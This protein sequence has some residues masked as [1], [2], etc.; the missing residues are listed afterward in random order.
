MLKEEKRRV[1]ATTPHPLLRTLLIAE[2]LG[3]VLSPRDFIGI[4]VEVESLGFFATHALIT[5]VK[6]G[7]AS[8]TAKKPTP[9]LIA[10]L[11]LLYR[12]PP[13][14][15]VLKV[16]RVDDILAVY[17]S[18]NEETIIAIYEPGL[19]IEV[20]NLK[21][22]KQ[23]D[24]VVAAKYIVIPPWLNKKID[25]EPKMTIR[26]WRVYRANG[27]YREIVLANLSLL[28]SAA[29]NRLATLLV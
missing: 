17:V 3:K 15:A 2:E 29:Q 8:T 10:Y 19:G 25:A 12:H 6:L 1:A 13:L 26:G 24:V 9:K 21:R 14:F 27:E 18:D 20:K 7:V 11:I 5:A 28:L 16:K 23:G 4:D 22:A